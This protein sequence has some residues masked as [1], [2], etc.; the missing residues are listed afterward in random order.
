MLVYRSANGKTWP[1]FFLEGRAPTHPGGLAKR[2]LNDTDFLMLVFSQTTNPQPT[3][4]LTSKNTLQFWKKIHPLSSKR[5]QHSLY[6]SQPQPT[7][8]TTRGAGENNPPTPPWKLRCYDLIVPVYQSYHHLEGPFWWWFICFFWLE[9]NQKRQ[10]QQ[11]H[12]G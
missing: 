11:E 8:H 9:E 1:I 2:P 3:W 5:P 4:N 12:L 6:N 7:Y 10:W